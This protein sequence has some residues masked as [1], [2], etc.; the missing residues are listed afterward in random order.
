M[1]KGIAKWTVI[2]R[3]CLDMPR[4]GADANG[5]QACIVEMLEPA[6][7]A[8]IC[9]DIDYTFIS[10][11]SQCFDCLPN[12]APLQKWFAFAAL[13]KTD[14][15]LFSSLQMRQCNLDDFINCGNKGQAIPGRDLDLARGRKKDWET[16]SSQ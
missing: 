15:G 2:G 9:I 8:R 3:I 5:V 16:R 6:R 13:P 4:N 7:I 1:L 10:L 12:A 14:N 11:S